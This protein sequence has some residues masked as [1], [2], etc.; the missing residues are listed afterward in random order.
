VSNTGVG[1][2]PCV[3]GPFVAVALRT[4]LISDGALFAS[5]RRR[6]CGPEPMKDPGPAANPVRSMDPLNS[7]VLPIPDAAQLGRIAVRLFLAALLGWL[8]GAE[9][10][11][12]GK[13]AGSRTHMLVALGAALFIIVP[14]EIG[15]K[16]GDLGRII[17]GIATGVGF[18]GAGTILKRTDRNE[19]TGLTTAATIWLTAAIGLGVGAGQVW[20]SVMCA[21]SAWIIL[22]LLALGERRSSRTSLNNDE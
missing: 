21:V 18:L 13:A 15:L 20:I 9:R 10:E 14:A 11:S 6:R 8:L 19:I 12:M 17:Q 22:Y 16:E 3:A 7:E 2:V 5:I 4:A 1:D